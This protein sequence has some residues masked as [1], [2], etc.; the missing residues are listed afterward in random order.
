MGASL[1]QF[2]GSGTLIVSFPGCLLKCLPP[3]PGKLHP[4]LPISPGHFLLKEALDNPQH[5]YS[6]GLG[7]YPC[8]LVRGTLVSPM[9]LGN[10]L[11][12]LARGK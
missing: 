6:C 1:L 5:L 2:L 9:V 4:S 12:V 3:L 8:C 7:Y 10:P 11:S